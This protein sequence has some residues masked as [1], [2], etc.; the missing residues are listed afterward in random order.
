MKLTSMPAHIQSFVAD[1]LGRGFAVWLIGSQA[2]PTGKPPSD[3]DF[4]VFGN[5]ALLDELSSQQPIP[6]VDLLIVFDGDAFK[7]PWPRASDS[8]I[9]SGSLTNWKWQHI[10]AESS[11]YKGTKWPHDWGSTKRAI[12]LRA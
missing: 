2:N 9:K 12:R 6:D 11:S 5:E 3:W 4:M 1:L 10:S 7:S 8:D